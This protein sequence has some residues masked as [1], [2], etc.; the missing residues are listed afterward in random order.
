MIDFMREAGEMKQEIIR[1]RRQ[2]HQM[3]EL[4]LDLPKTSQ[5]VMDCLEEYG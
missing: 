5:Y 1:N 4:G 3:P 2:L